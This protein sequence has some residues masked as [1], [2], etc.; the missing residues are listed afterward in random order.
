MQNRGSGRGAEKMQAIQVINR[1]KYLLREHSLLAPNI[2]WHATKTMWRKMCAQL[3]FDRTINL[4]TNIYRT[5]HI[6]SF[7]LC[8]AVGFVSFVKWK[9]H[10]IVSLIVIG[11][12]RIGIVCY[13]RWSIAALIFLHPINVKPLIPLTHVILPFLRHSFH[14]C[15][16]FRSKTTRQSHFTQ[17][18]GRLGIAS[19]WKYIIFQSQTIWMVSLRSHGDAHRTR[20]WY[21]VHPHCWR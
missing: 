7:S 19:P 14:L 5:V 9:C 13:I 3:R 6:S 18:A 12:R 4:T 15:V 2:Q 17:A 8:V 20:I 1:I 10:R 21:I 11:C 16:S